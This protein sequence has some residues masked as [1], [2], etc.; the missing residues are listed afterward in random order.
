MPLIVPWTYAAPARTAATALAV[1]TPKSLW[2]WKCTG[3]SGPTQLD[4]RADELRDRLGRGD[5]ERVDDHDLLARRPRP[6]SSR[7]GGRSRARRASSRRRRTR[8]GCRCSAANRIALRDPLEHRVARDADRVELQVGDRRLDHREADAELDERLQVGR[9][10]AREAPD[11]GAQP[12]GRDQLDRVPVVVPRRA[13]SRPRS[14]RSRARRAAG[15]SRA[16]ARG[17]ARRRPSAR[18]RGASCRRGRRARRGDTGRSASRS[19]SGR[20]H[21]VVTT[22]SGNERELLGARRS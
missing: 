12:G 18:R 22:P 16:S 6:R 2:P 4:G 9:H 5:A 21:A 20:R 14:G 7:R 8:R 19:R 1:A 10:G 13:G 11:L 3:T 15:R 17:R